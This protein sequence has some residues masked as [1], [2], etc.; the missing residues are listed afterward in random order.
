MSELGEEK[1]EHSGKIL[2]VELSP[3]KPDDLDLLKSLLMPFCGSVEE[4]REEQE[5]VVVSFNRGVEKKHIEALG[6]YTLNILKTEDSSVDTNE[7]KTKTNGKHSESETNKTN[8]DVKQTR[9]RNTN[10]ISDRVVIDEHDIINIFLNQTLVAP[11]IFVFLSI[12]I[13]ASLL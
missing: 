2:K 5:V 4:F 1:K 13:F 3:I 7:E 11:V 10:F 6:D 8:T 12:M 9:K